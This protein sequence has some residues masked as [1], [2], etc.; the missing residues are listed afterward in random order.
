M[1]YKTVSTIQGDHALYRRITA[2]AATENVPEPEQWVSSSMW[3]FAAQPGWAAA[4]ESAVAAN[5]EDIGNNEGVITDYA[6]LSAL[7][8]VK[9]AA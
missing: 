5:V 3:K 6:I 9:A 2:C 1:S 8:A 4:W 7:Q